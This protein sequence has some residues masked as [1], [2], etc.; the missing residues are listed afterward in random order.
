MPGVTVFPTLTTANSSTVTVSGGKQDAVR[1]TVA[2]KISE[3]NFVDNAVYHAI[4]DNNSDVTGRKYTVTKP[5]KTDIQVTHGRR[6]AFT[7][8]E[9]SLLLQHYPAD[10]VNVSPPAFFNSASLITGQT[11]PVLLFAG[12]S[13][14]RPDSITTATK[15][16]RLNLKNLKGKT[17]TQLGMTQVDNLHAGQ[18]VNVGLRTTDIILRLFKDKQH[19][20]NS[21]SLG[22]PVNASGTSG[23]TTYKGNANIKH[24][25]TFLSK[26][27]YRRTIP[28]AARMLGRSDNY[29][30]YHDNFGNFIYAPN[31]FS[32]TDRILDSSIAGSVQRSKLDDV[33]NRVV[34]QGVK[35]ALNDDNS[36]T[37][38]DTEKQKEAGMVKSVTVVDPTATSIQATTRSARQMLRLNRKANMALSVKE[39]PLS[40]YLQP[41]DVVTYK[42]MEM[43]ESRQAIVEVKHDLMNNKSDF[44]MVSYDTGLEKVLSNSSNQGET[45]QEGEVSFDAGIVKSAKFNMG[46]ANWKVTADTQRRTVAVNKARVHSGTTGITDLTTTIDRHSG[47]LIGHRGYDIG[48]SAG[49]S[50]LGTGL[51]PRTSMSGIVGS[52]ITVTST[53]GFPSSGA[54]MV[55]KTATVAAHVAY[56]GKTSTTFTGVTLQ[57]PSGGSIPTGSCDINLLRPKS[58]EI[59][60]VKGRI[61]RGRL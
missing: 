57:A 27:M 56:T 55:R 31:N 12:D 5:L 50:A 51:T 38:D 46:Y 4:Y 18:I 37:L 61:I 14:I 32:Q 35:I 28:Q 10:G 29:A 13:K 26:N 52:T 48:N 53:D 22:R 16:S 60:V 1:T 33:P 39:I 58:H 36:I 47:F 45:S 6:Y 44:A 9:D 17:L 54:L 42:D 21:V 15:G 2:S 34:L 24:S 41:G 59:G 23:T 30:I 40:G 11:P 8:E 7:E 25:T 19:A 43:G 20:L 3:P 49:R